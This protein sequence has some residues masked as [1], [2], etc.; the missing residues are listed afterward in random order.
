MNIVKTSIPDVLV[1]EPRVF[2]D[3]RG[4]C[5]ESLSQTEGEEEVCKARMVRDEG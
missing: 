4:Y 1:L 2:S 3:P 5:F